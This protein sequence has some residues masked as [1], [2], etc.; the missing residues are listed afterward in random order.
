M[1]KFI[2]YFS[3]QCNCHLQGKSVMY[4]EK[5]VCYKGLIMVIKRWVWGGGW[6]L[7]MV[8]CNGKKPQPDIS[9][10][11]AARAEL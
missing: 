8:L 2:Q 9:L 5:A 11:V 4:V 1:L 3:T 7:S 10:T 6:G